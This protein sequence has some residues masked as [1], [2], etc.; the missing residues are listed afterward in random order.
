MGTECGVCLMCPCAWT[1]PCVPPALLV[2]SWDQRAVDE[3]ASG[4]YGQYEVKLPAAMVQTSGAAVF[5]LHQ[6]GVFP[7]K[8]SWSDAPYNVFPVLQVSLFSR[9][10]MGIKGQ[11]ITANC[12]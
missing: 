7:I 12:T 11:T 6:A 2:M 5:R 3:M 10:L 1:P 4:S 9:N 8:L